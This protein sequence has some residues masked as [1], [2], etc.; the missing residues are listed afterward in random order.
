LVCLCG[1]LIQ[2]SPDLLDDSLNTIT[3]EKWRGIPVDK[4]YDHVTSYNTFKRLAASLLEP[5]AHDALLFYR[6]EF[7]GHTDVVEVGIHQTGLGDF[8]A[9]EGVLLKLKVTARDYRVASPLIDGIIRTR[10]IPKKFPNGPSIHVPFQ[11]SQHSVDVLGIL[12]ESLKFFDKDLISLASVRSYKTAN[13]PVHGFPEGQVPRESVYETELMRILTNWLVQQYKWTVTGQWHLRTE[14]G[15][16]KYIDIVLKKNESIV[17]ELLA[18]GDRSFVLSHIEKA[19]E[20][21]A[22]HS[23]DQAWVVHFT[24]E[25]NYDPIWQS[26]AQ[27]QSGLNVVH[28]SHDNTFTNVEVFAR[29]KDETGMQRHYDARLKL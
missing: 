13:V 3:L 4:L 16:N 17:L 26:E 2:E 23:A 12:L 1:L 14:D 6:H 20:Y 9:A 7:A 24:C 10:I 22:L 18:T 21:M 11:E 27:L 19:P 25:Q 5:R 8:L 29:W 15:R 28:F